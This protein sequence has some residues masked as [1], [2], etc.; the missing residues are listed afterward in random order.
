MKREAVGER[1]ENP[2]AIQSDRMGIS[3]LNGT[4]IFRM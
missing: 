2:R 3:F 4:Q 1:A